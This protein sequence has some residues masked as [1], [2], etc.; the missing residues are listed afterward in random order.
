MYISVVICT[1]NRAELLED[2]LQKVECQTLDPSEYELLIVDNGSRDG[3]SRLIQEY[4]KSRGHVRYFREDQLGLSHARNR[5]WKEAKGLYVGYLD[6][7]AHPPP[8]WLERAKAIIEEKYPHAFGGPYYAEFST[9]PPRWYRYGSHVPSKEAMFL[10]RHQFGALRG[11]NLF[12]RRSVLARYGGFRPDLGM[13]GRRLAYGEE[14]ELLRRISLQEADPRLYYDPELYVHHLVAPQK[15][16]LPWILR[17]RFHGGRYSYHSVK[18]RSSRGTALLL[19]LMAWQS[20][21]LGMDLVKGMLFRDRNA[22]PHYFQYLYEVALDHVRHLGEYYEEYRHC[23][24]Q[25]GKK[26]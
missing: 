13:K 10:Q 26:R 6:D 2:T 1:F 14:T 18:G 8:H 11:G 17:H 15:M 5:G 25:R 23:R 24:L 9:P 22:F 7:D 3:T 20:L 12:L 19:I 4:S 21:L 16:T